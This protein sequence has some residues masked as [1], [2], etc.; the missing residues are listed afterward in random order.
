MCNISNGKE[1]KWCRYVLTTDVKNKIQI[2]DNDVRNHENVL[3][4][5]KCKIRDKIKKRKKI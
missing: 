2:E 5:K 4:R 1:Q 3:K